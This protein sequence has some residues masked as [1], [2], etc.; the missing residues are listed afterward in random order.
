MLVKI[1]KVL[2]HFNPLIFM[3]KIIFLSSS[4]YTKGKEE[5]YQDYAILM[6][7]ILMDLKRHCL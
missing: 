4:E 6:I 5:S 3:L 2:D 1:L 7:R